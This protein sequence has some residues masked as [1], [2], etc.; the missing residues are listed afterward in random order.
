MDVKNAFLKGDLEEGVYMEQP[1]ENV[2]SYFL[3]YVCRLKKDLYRLKQAPRAWKNRMS[4]FLKSINFEINKAN[5]S[6][7]V[8]EIGCGLFVAVI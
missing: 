4:K 6:L 3:H 1:E 7:Y 2:H 8:K 5:H